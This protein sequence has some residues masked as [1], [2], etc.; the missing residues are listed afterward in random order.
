MGPVYRLARPPTV[1]SPRQLWPRAL[2]WLVFLGPF[3]FLSY[4]LATWVTAQR[5]DVGFLVFAWESRVPFVPWTI[6]PYWSI[7]LF[8]GLSLF[9]CRTR[10]QLDTHARRLFTAQVLAVACFLIGPLRCTYERGAVGGAFGAM[11]DLLMS[12]DQPYNQ[13]PS[14]HIALLV[15]L[16]EPY[17]RATPRVAR[18]LVWGVAL[19]IAVSVMTTWQHHF[20]DLPTGLWL[21]C[22]VV[23]LWPSAAPSPLRRARVARDPRRLRLAG[24]Y[25]G[26]ALLLAAIG[27]LGGGT[28]TWLLWPS[29]SLTVVAAIYACFDGSAFGK[30][31]DGSMPL[32]VRTLLA[33]YLLGAWLNARCWAQRL[34]A[35]DQV[36]PGL[37]VGRL[38]SGNDLDRLPMATIVDLCAELPCAAIRPQRVLVPWLDLATPTEQELDDA[39][40]AID[41]ARHAGPV[42]VCCALG[43]AR[44]A[45]AVAAWLL[46]SGAATTPE[47]AIAQVRQARPAVVL[48][49]AD[50]AMLHAWQQRASAP[51]RP[52]IG[53]AVRPVASAEP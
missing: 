20:V 10:R 39:C 50:A 42:W 3:F 24:A 52:P 18:P 23:W 22:F 45:R 11:F 9:L 29:G 35:A 4:G 34:P 5:A 6:V 13:A 26:A 41:R 53:R 46:R 33:P 12:F 36:L 17:L 28:A 25:G 21:G 48:G 8:Y 44:S 7:D 43:L 37:W 38:P 51:T 49:S 1:T 27:M 15:L 31:A 40:A 14:L 16:L 32:A 2:A 47:E 19:L 30:R